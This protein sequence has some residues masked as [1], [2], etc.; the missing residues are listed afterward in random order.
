MTHA[1]TGPHRHVLRSLLD[2]LLDSALPQ[3]CVVCGTWI[4]G[5]TGLTCPACHERNMT[6]LALPACPRCA[7]TVPPFGGHPRGCGACQREDFWK[8]AG[9]ARCGPYDDSLVDLLTGLK[10]AGRRRNA[11]YLGQLLA[12]AIRR[13]AWPDALQTLVPVPMHWRRRLQRPVDHAR[14]LAEVAGRTLGIPVR[15]ATVRRVQYS[16]SQTLVTSRAQ[17]FENVRGCFGTSRWANVRG[18]VVC[19]VDN[20][21]VSGAT[22]HEVAKVLRKAGARRIYAAVVARSVMPNEVP[23]EGATRAD[24]PPTAPPAGGGSPAPAGT[25]AAGTPPHTTPAGPGPS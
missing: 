6:L 22:I 23:F 5:R 14:A 25:A 2:S 12:G 1:K 21:L 15:C 4:P 20:L 10:Y 9:V 19:I 17:R 24:W 18:Q 16:P 13:A 11:V 8:V 3:T 7:R